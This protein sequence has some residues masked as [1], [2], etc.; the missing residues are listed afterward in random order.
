M[1]NHSM[2]D[3]THRISSCLPASVDN[4]LD[5]IILI[6]KKW[7]R[8]R[9]PQQ[10]HILPF[11]SSPVSS[12]SLKDS[13]LC[14]DCDDESNPSL[15]PPQSFAAALLAT[16]SSS[17]ALAAFLGLNLLFMAIEAAVG[18]LTH[19][20]TLT[21]DAAHMLIDCAA[22]GVGLIGE[23]SA[24]WPAN[25]QHPF[26]YGRFDQLCALVNALLLLL[27]A[28]SVVGEALHRMAH[29][30]HY[31]EHDDARL[32]PVA[33]AGLVVNLIGLAYFHN[34][35]HGH[36]GGENGSDDC[37]NGQCG[38]LHPFDV[39]NGKGKGK[40]KNGKNGNGAPKNGKLNGA[41]INGHS[42]GGGDNINMRGVFLHV[43]ADT[44]GSLATI[45]SS[46][47]AK[48]LG[49][50][51]AD[52]ICSLL[53][54]GCIIAAALPLLRDAT[55]LL[56]LRTPTALRGDGAERCADAIRK[57]AHVRE[58]RRSRFWCHTSSRA[59][60]SVTVVCEPGANERSIVAGVERVVRLYGVHNVVVEVEIA[61][62]PVN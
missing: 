2:Q 7:R 55:L 28:L 38:H 17:P 61:D 13:S 22:L 9:K 30:K 62:D 47:L 51:W 45:A 52:P 50:Q 41:S 16:I 56:L 39:F 6:R 59:H 44:M 49:W 15:P 31:F 4:L 60:G 43:L 29:A 54:A 25:A 18:V 53:V 57:L 24:K 26:G 1:A 33:V 3:I 8:R 35:R 32:L 46:L 34:F 40:T 23:V 20:L 10:Q 48:H 12:V 21:T 5:R 58:I 36:G 11:T 27:V 37:A 19:S 14:G 42:N